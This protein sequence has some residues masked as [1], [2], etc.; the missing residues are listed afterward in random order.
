MVENYVLPSSKKLCS[1]FSTILGS[2]LKN[3]NSYNSP[4]YSAFEGEFD[5]SITLNR[6]LERLAFYCLPEKITLV[7]SL[8]LLNKFYSKMNF[9]LT[10]RNIYKLFLT[11]LV[12]S[13]K[14]LEDQVVTNKNFAK[15]GGI[16][17]EELSIL[18]TLFLEGLGYEVC[19]T[20][21]ELAQFVRMFR[22]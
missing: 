6:Y 21:K 14:L 13:Q 18:E 8:S 5:Q 20:D 16:N 9:T 1:M 17:P 4:V 19:L 3:E 15:A 22:R 11:S 7:Y 12:I 2:L 10:Q